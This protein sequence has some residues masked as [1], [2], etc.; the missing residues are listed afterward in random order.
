MREEIP[1]STEPPEATVEEVT[2][3]R[4]N[5]HER[6]LIEPG[7]AFGFGVKCGVFSVHLLFDPALPGEKRLAA[8]R[9]SPRS[10]Q[11]FAIEGFVVS[12]EDRVT[13]VSRGG[14]PL[15]DDETVSNEPGEKTKNNA[16][17]LKN[18]CEEEWTEIPGRGRRTAREESSENHIDQE[19]EDLQ[20]D[21][22]EKC[23]TA[24]S[25]KTEEEAG[26]PMSIYGLRNGDGSPDC[27][28]AG[29]EGLGHGGGRDVDEDGIEGDDQRSDEAPEG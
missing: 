9:G 3:V 17:E 23:R 12:E 25:E 13:S 8:P 1:E 20:A 14:G 11:H 16:Q 2:G 7:I 4:L 28:E 18:R 26:G 10:V 21:K 24:E 27:N 6:E 29:T 15:A 5:R 22:G 19:G